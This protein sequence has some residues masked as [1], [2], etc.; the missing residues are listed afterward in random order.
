MSEKT[1]TAQ[2]KQ[3]VRLRAS[4]CC[5]YCRSQERFATQTFS[6]DHIQPLSKGG[7]NTLDN[8][9]LACQGCN[10]HKYTKTDAIDPV[11]GEMIP[12]YHP[13]QQR[14]QDHFT[15]NDDYTLIVGLTATGRGT[16]T[17]LHLNREGLVNLRRMLYAMAEH[18]PP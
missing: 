15:W 14:W 9:A 12:L 7:K 18:P 13:R 5:E 17:A 16:V 3:T 10:N 4:G 2:Q 8:L 11:S 1:I 6:V